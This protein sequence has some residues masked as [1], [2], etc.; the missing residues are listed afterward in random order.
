MAYHARHPLFASASDDGALHIF[1]GM[2]YQVRPPLGM[3][4]PYCGE[5]QKVWL[6]STRMEG[7]SV[8]LWAMQVT[9]CLSP[10]VV[11][12]LSSGLTVSWYS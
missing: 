3:Q 7:R 1:H 2:V 10:W 11:K 9:R 5:E 8:V 4:A 6:C 12:V